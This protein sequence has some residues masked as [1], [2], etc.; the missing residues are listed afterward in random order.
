MRGRRQHHRRGSPGLQ[1]GSA[2]QRNTPAQP[3]RVQEAQRSEIVVDGEPAILLD[4]VYSHYV[5]R[6][7]AVR[8]GDRLCVLTPVACSERAAEFPRVEKR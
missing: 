1:A 7:M 2:A 6:K 8:Y 3:R 5:L 4:D